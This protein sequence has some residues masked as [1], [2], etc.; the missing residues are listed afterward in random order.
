MD[1]C[2]CEATNLHGPRS[3]TRPSR[4]R[5]PSPP[6]SRPAPAHINSLLF[7]V[8][9]HRLPVLA[10]ALGL[11]VSFLVAPVSIPATTTAARAAAVAIGIVAAPDSRCP[12]STDF[13]PWSSWTPSARF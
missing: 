8:P 9:A 3:E 1:I 4:E 11:P 12:V 7:L 13:L 5:P 10:H 6:P 2:S